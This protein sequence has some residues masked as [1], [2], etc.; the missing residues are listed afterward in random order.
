M[1][2][3]TFVETPHQCMWEKSITILKAKRKKTL[4]NLLKL[5]NQERIIKTKE[6]VSSPHPSS[7]PS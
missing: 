4:K 3:I 6:K 1:K 7:N 2:K 5:G